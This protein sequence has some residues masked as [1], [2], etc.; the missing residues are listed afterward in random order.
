MDYHH[1]PVKD[2]VYKLLVGL[3]QGRETWDDTLLRVLEH[4]LKMRERCEE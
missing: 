3:T 4:Y 1:I 2:K